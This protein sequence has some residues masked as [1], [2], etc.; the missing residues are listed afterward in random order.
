MA[1]GGAWNDQVD[2]YSGIYI[3]GYRG[4]LVSDLGFVVGY[5]D[6]FDEQRFLTTEILEE[7]TSGAPVR[8]ELLHFIGVRILVPMYIPT[9]DASN[10]LIFGK[11]S[12]TNPKVPYP[13]NRKD[14]ELQM[15]K[16]GSEE[17]APY[18][19]YVIEAML[20]NPDFK[21]L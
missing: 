2:K 11:N 17:L 15:N 9:A 20:K 5:M 16:D 13:M 21:A 4:P 3:K 1:N 14:C 8:P 18:L 19:D 6:P 12:R 10:Y 7:L